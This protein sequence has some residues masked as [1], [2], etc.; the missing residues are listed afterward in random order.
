L[1]ATHGLPE[2][3][4][5][6]LAAGGGDSAVVQCLRA[7][8]HS[9]QIMLLH[10]VAEA[11]KDADPASPAVVAFQPAYK[12]LTAVQERAPDAISWMFNLPH[13]SAWAHDCLIRLDR[14]LL[15]DFGYLASAAA[16]TAVRAGVSFEL[17]VPVCDGVALLPGLGRFLLTDRHAWLPLRCDGEC[18]SIGPV[19]DAACS[20]LV[21]DDGS[22]EQIPHWQGTLAVRAVAEGQAWNILLETSDRYLDRYGLSMATTLTA[23][24]AV[25]WRQLIQ[26]AWQLL[27]SQHTWAAESIAEGVAVIIPLTARSETDLD[28]ATT[29]AAFGAIATSQPPAPVILAETLVHEFQHLK[30]CGLMDMVPLIEPCDEKVY[31]PWRQDPRPAGG[32]LQGVYA[33]LGIARF[34]NAQRHVETEPDDI[35]RANVMFHRWRSTIEP[36][37][38]TLLET[39]CLTA[40]GARFVEIL[41]DEG[42]SLEPEAVPAK[43]RNIAGEVALDHRLTWRLR[44][45][46][47]D[48][49]EVADLTAA[50]ARGEPL[51][52]RPLPEARIEDDTRK[53]D[54][55]VRGRVLSLRY[56]EPRRFGEA[57]TA[58]PGL[59]KADV[60]LMRGDA[61]NAV[62][63]Y[64]DEITAA[65]DDQPDAWIGLALAISRLAR[66]PLQQAFTTQLPLMF[67]MHAHLRERGIASDPLELAD[68][69]AWPQP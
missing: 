40:A 18:V 37:T 63:A 24:E 19:T 16:S 69:F 26:S 38:S 56:L 52:D 43:A 32:L 3:A 27:V 36:A 53:I 7:A 61:E 67:D 66:A 28:S 50:Y 64:R 46:M 31:A 35:L 45:T 10:A 60:L 29:P 62:Q 33:H 54:S 51:G 11:A 68:W 65:A 14:G 34:W 13:I 48:V 30:L 8:Q 6:A 41:R 58:V 22:T 2:E 17:D 59:S 1:I 55:T 20:A 23:A 12:L 9:K 25:A 42:L 47:I 44:H 15:P 57:A 21:P 4:F 39:G 49:A 5:M